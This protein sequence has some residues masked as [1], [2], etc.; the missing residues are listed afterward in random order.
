METIIEYN[1]VMQGE[2]GDAPPVF[3]VS[4]NSFSGYYGANKKY[5]L[6][7]LNDYLGVVKTKTKKKTLCSDESSP[8]N[9]THF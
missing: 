6:N 8:S 2:G 9:S 4:E 5:F 1:W 7:F 3:F